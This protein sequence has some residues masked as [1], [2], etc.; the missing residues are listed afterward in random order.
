MTRDLNYLQHFFGQVFGDPLHRTQC[1]WA[2]CDKIVSKASRTNAAIVLMIQR[3]NPADSLEHVVRSATQSMLCR[4]CRQ[5]WKRRT[6]CSRDYL[7]LLSSRTYRGE[8]TKSQIPPQSI[9][10]C[11]LPCQDHDPRSNSGICLP[12]LQN[13]TWDSLACVRRYK[14]SSAWTMVDRS[15][16]KLLCDARLISTEICDDSHNQQGTEYEDWGRQVETL[17]SCMKY[18]LDAKAS[19]KKHLFVSKD[20]TILN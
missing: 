1:L 5:N 9:H 8:R 10:M 12:S 3:R 4:S 2:K 20:T 17:C 16:R 6:A 14:E 19:V 18:L 7:A 13:F 11:S 15:T